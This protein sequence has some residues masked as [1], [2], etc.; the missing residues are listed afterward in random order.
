MFYTNILWNWFLLVGFGEGTEGDFQFGP[1]ITR[2]HC[3]S[4]YTRE[5]KKSLWNVYK[6]SVLSHASDLRQEMKTCFCYE[7]HQ[8]VKL[9]VLSRCWNGYIESSWSHSSLQ[10]GE[11]IASGF[12]EVLCSSGLHNVFSVGIAK[13][14][15]WSSLWKNKLLPNWRFIDLNL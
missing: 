8:T 13:Y 2:K 12:P 7:C 10:H 4:L 11:G 1:P 5:G 9:E 14:L 3:G 6:I 15:C